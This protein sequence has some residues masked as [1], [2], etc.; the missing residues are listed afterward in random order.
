MPRS[1]LCTNCR[2]CIQIPMRGDPALEFCENPK[3]KEG[4]NP[5]GF[6]KRGAPACW[7]YESK[8]A[9]KTSARTTVILVTP[10]DTGREGA[11]I[12][13]A[14]SGAVRMAVLLATLSGLYSWLTSH[15]PPG[16]AAFM[17]SLWAK[18][19]S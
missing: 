9:P 1:K 18:L 17:A 8:R 3:T 15:L 6:L 10:L 4:P 19:R 2:H 7:L 13:R 12:A 16:L 11:K 14:E 5:I